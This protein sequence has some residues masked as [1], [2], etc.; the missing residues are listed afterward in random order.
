MFSGQA[1][2]SL[3]EIDSLTSFFIPLLVVICM[4]P[5]VKQTPR[6]IWVV[7]S[8]GSSI[9]SMYVSLAWF[10]SN[11]CWFY[12]SGIAR[13][14]YWIHRDHRAGFQVAAF[15]SYIYSNFCNSTWFTFVKRK[16]KFDD[17][18]DY[19]FLLLQSMESTTN[20]SVRSEAIALVNRMD[21]LI[22]SSTTP[23]KDCRRD[24]NHFINTNRVRDHRLN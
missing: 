24:K 13:G 20:A 18:A 4:Y 9:T 12:P 11:G 23:Y 19:I 14:F 5:V 6:W 17:D 1:T 2:S 7:P 3:T 8:L 16:G 10:L 15:T 22:L 21:A